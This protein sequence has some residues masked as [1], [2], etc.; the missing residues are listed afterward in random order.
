MTNAPPISLP[1]LRFFRRIVRGYFRRHFHAVR[2]SG[3]AGFSALAKSDAGPM[4]VYANH[5][6]WWDPMVSVYLAER[7]M[8]AR[9]HYAPMDAA[10][11]ERYAVLKRVGIFGV[12]MNSTRGAATFLRTSE[13]ILAS[14]GVVWITPQGRFV[15]SRTRPLE[16]KPGLSALASRV[17]ASTGWCTV[18]PLAIEYPFWDERLPECLLH[19]G[20]TVRVESGDDPEILQPRLVSSLEVA[21]NNLSAIA[22]QRDAQSFDTLSHGKLGT[23][24][25]YGGWQ[26]LK[27]FLIR[28][29]YYAEHTAKLKRRADLASSTERADDDV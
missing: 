16:F 1:A 7:F 20:E 12:E 13:A 22:M 24:G 10:A 23:G 4:I 21:M 27:A 9:Q 25:F 17:A 15:D 26:R 11:L 6:S 5:S 2:I 28:G 18:V 29:P 3:A 14:G 19:F 8:S